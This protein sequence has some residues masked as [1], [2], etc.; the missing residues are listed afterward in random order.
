MKNLSQ[1]FGS[2]KV[3][4]SQ[5]TD[6][7]QN[8][9]SKIS[10]KYNLMNDLM[11][12]GAHRLWKKRLIEM[13]NIQDN[14]T[15]IDVGAGTGDIG[16]KISSINKKV[17]VFL[18]DLNLSMIKSG[19]KNNYLNNKNVKWI[20]M[21]SEALPFKNNS[22]D[23]YIISFCLRN[24]T[25]INK[26]LKESLRVLKEGGEFFCL[27]FSTVD[28]LILNTF[29]NSYKNIFIP[30]LGKYITSQKNA[31][32]YLSESIDNFPNQ[33]I[34]SGKLAKTGYKEV[35]YKN[36]FGGI[37]SIHKGWKI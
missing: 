26:T 23:K 30:F 37:V 29:Y 25:D 19:M 16:L 21:N 14:Q 4:K 6:L 17:N 7:V 12:F 34:L 33:E 10:T 20:N 15:I 24:V 11:S 36:L 3:L 28:M 31:Y 35:S 13:I 1:F 18:G 2:K 8:V 5:K 22:F 27:E 32:K 9:F